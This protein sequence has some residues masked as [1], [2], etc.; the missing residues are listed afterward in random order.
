MK[1]SYSVRITVRDES[2]FTDSIDVTIKVTDVNE[3][4]S[5]TAGSST[6]RTI[7]ENA[8]VGIDI[9]P[10]YQAIDQ[11]TGDTVTY[12][13]QRGDKDM[14]RIDPNTG[15]LRTHAALDYE[16]N[17]AYTDLVVRATDSQGSITAIPAT[18]HVTNVNEAPT[19]TEGAT[20]TRTIAEN[21]ASGEN[22]GAPI[23]AT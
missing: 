1:A 4:P 16:T 22:I 7:V 8:G 14:F 15:Q 11:D 13:L 20:A 2:F 10:P 3:A 17:K 19:F 21:T 6:T 12:S 18:I 23:A 5:F 9:G